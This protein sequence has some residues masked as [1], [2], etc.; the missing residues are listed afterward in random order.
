MEIQKLLD[1]GHYNNK[2]LLHKHQYPKDLQQ[3]STTAHSDNNEDQ[4]LRLL[5]GFSLSN[6]THYYTAQLFLRISLLLPHH[7][8]CYPEHNNLQYNIGYLMSML[9]RC[10]MECIQL[11]L[12]NR[13][14]GMLC[15]QKFLHQLEQ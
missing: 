3:D 13:H 2:R 8:I 14:Q 15:S 12:Q 7:G 5:S 1:M 9:L 6:T 11:L 10:L 4:L